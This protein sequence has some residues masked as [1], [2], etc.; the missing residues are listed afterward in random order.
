MDP[1]NIDTDGDGI[2]DLHDI[3]E[4]NK[5]NGGETPLL[6]SQI[7][8]NRIDRMPNTDT[9]NASP[10]NQGTEQPMSADFQMLDCQRVV[11]QQV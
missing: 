11:Y 2:I 5:P 10:P 4:Q 3:P 9:P 8:V 7:S 1:N 6:N